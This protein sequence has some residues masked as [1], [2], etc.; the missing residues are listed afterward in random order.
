MARV[1]GRAEVHIQHALGYDTPLTGAGEA[2]ILDGVLEVKE[3]AGLIARVALVHQHGAAAQEIAV[4]IQGEVDDSI[5][6][7]MAGADEGRERLAL[8]G[9]Q[10]FLEGDALI[11]RQHRFANAD[12]AV[13]VT[14]RGGDVGNLIAAWLALLDRTAQALRLLRKNDSM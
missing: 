3:H 8:R 1:A 11:A 5:E 13:A 12:E 2:G 9:D 14:H 6:Q 4:P 10:P 7:G